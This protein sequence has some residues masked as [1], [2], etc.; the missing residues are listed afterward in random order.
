[1][2][3]C[4]DRE[5]GRLIGFLEYLGSWSFTVDGGMG[6]QRFGCKMKKEKEKKVSIRGICCLLYS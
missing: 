5:V 1:L 6:G 4:L 3:G 2:S